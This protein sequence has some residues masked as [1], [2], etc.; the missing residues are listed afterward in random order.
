MADWAGVDP[1]STFCC[2]Q[3]RLLQRP[4]T[5]CAECGAPTTAPLDL[6]R[7]LLHYRDLSLL[8]HRGWGFATAFLAGSSFALPIL[9]PL[10]VGSMIAFAVGRLRGG[11]RRRAITGVAI[12]PAAAA[13][14]AVTLYGVARR[15]RST[16]ASL[17]DDSPV[18][19]EHAAF[20]DRSGAVLLR[21]TQAAPFLLELED[22]GPVLVTGVAGVAAGHLPARRRVGRRGVARG[23]KMGGAR[24]GAGAARGASDPR[25]AAAWGPGAGEA[26]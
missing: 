18:L 7:E 15:F 11:R 24:D 25:V 20:K 19:I 14:G 12:P 16:V 2:V 5:S 22:R 23:A 17:V 21:R 9:A 13:P 3:C 26:G 4:A 6:V 1:S 10:A 8:D